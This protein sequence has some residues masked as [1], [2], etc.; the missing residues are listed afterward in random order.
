M[1]PGPQETPPNTAS[2][3]PP[4]TALA[5]ERIWAQKARATASVT[6]VT[7]R[8][9]TGPNRSVSAPH[10]VVAR[11]PAKDEAESNKV[12]KLVEKCRTLCRYTT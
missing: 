7:S 1:L 6:L 5:G 8:I 9:A 11:R 4:T 3:S 10:Q 12:A 2:I